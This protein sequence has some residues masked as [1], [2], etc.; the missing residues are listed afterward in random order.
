MQVEALV[1]LIV[2]VVIVGI[3]LVG[4]AVGLKYYGRGEVATAARTDQ[5]QR[6]KDGEIM[7]VLALHDNRVE[8]LTDEQR[9]ALKRYQDAQRAAEQARRD[10]AAQEA[11]YRRPSNSVFFDPQR[12]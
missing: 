12:Y 8:E 4:F 9:L 10:Q 11:I 3:L 1:G 2:A 6:V 7:D 5:V